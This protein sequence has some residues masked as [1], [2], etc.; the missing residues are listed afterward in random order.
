MR[1]FFECTM[2]GDLSSDRASEQYPTEKVCASC[3][4]KFKKPDLE[5]IVAVG[6]DLGY[7][8]GNECFLVD[9]H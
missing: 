6:S 1:H 4:R 5:I 8:D 9:R 3:I 2:W 7:D